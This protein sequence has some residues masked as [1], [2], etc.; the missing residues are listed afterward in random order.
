MVNDT[1]AGEGSWKGPMDLGTTLPDYKYIASKRRELYGAAL[2]YLIVCGSAG[3]ATSTRKREMPF[4][5][6]D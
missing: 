6:F 3:H 4:L 2:P 5:A 1:Q